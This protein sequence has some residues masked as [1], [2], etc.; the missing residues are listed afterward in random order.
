VIAELV[1]RLRDDTISNTNEFYEA[2]LQQ[3]RN[4]GRITAHR[5]GFARGQSLAARKLS[6]GAGLSAVG[7]SWPKDAENKV[8]AVFV[9][10]IPLDQEQNGI[11]IEA[12]VMS[13]ANDE[14]AYRALITCQ[15][16]EEM[17]SVLR[18]EHVVLS[19]YSNQPPSR[20]VLPNRNGNVPEK[21]I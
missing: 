15:R 18:S 13:L 21:K 14:M 20:D 9:A 19:A 6:I 10:A 12:A 3:E 5:I 8:H 7:I 16:P 11:A 17:Y 4:S 2:V 1:V